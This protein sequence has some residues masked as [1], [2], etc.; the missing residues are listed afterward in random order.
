[1]SFTTELLIVLGLIIVNGVFAMSEI[2][3][4]S[5]RKIRLKKMA[6]EGDTRA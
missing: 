4:V 3:I 2:A 5:A 6:D 1:M